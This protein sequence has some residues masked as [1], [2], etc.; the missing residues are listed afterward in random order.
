MCAVGA[1]GETRQAMTDLIEAPANVDEQNIQYASLLKSVNGEGDRPFQLLAANALW[2]QQGERFK[3]N[4]QEAIADF[5]HE[6]P[7]R[8]IGLL[9]A[10]SRRYTGLLSVSNEC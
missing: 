7:R 5:F 4:F 9:S 10:R 3:S 2:G 8:Y 1:R 6:T